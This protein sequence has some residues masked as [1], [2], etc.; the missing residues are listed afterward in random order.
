M[1]RRLSKLYLKITVTTPTEFEG[2]SEYEQ[3]E[4]QK[5][6]DYLQAVLPIDA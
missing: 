4:Y 3:E 5:L 1:V 2:L 6:K